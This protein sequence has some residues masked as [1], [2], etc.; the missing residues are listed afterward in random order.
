MRCLL[1]VAADD[2]GRASL[3]TLAA[4]NHVF[5]GGRGQNIFKPSMSLFDSVDKLV[6]HC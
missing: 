5:T 6:L 2:G 1:T 4:E 3:Q